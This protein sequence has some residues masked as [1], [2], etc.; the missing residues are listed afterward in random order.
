MKVMLEA[1]NHFEYV[2]KMIEQGYEGTPQIGEGKYFKRGAPYD[3]II[4]LKWSEEKIE[5]FIRAMTHPPYPFATYN[6]IEVKSISEL[7]NE[8]V[9]EE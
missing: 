8:I 9:N 7:K 4:S 6:G 1:F 5:R 3:G 2:L